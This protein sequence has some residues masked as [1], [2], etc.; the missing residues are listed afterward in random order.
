MG[1][2][3]NLSRTGRP[4]KGQS[5]SELMRR[6]VKRVEE[7]KGVSLFDHLVRKAY[8]DNALG[9]A[10]IRKLVPDLKS[11]DLKQVQ[12]SPF[13]LVIDVTP[14]IKSPTKTPK[15]VKRTTKR[16]VRSNQPASGDPS[17]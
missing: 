13:R 15:R 9:V 11:V 10:I 14:S 17:E 4:P 7:E 16:A 6:A 3:D 12:E 1:N 5:W 8:S 2:P